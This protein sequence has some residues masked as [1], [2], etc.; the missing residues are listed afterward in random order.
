[1]PT[2]DMERLEEQA[3]AYRVNRS[4]VDTLR[5]RKKALDE[6]E[7]QL[8]ERA[9]QLQREQEAL[10]KNQQTVKQMYERQRK[11]NQLL[12][13]A[14]GK[15][16]SLTKENGSLSRAMAQQAKTIQEL[17][18]RLET[19]LQTVRG[20][21]ESLTNVVKA[22]GMLKYD[23]QDGYGVALT[24]E[25]G[26]LVDAIAKYGARWARTDGQND[27]AQ[28]METKIGISEGIQEDIQELTPKIYRGRSGRGL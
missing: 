4:E 10:R 20:A 23:K 9:E 26:R 19:A 6:R 1:M 17:E 18:K 2:E 25:Q 28:I 7:Q 3:K 13:Q 21:Y 24:E 22:V 27:L 5:K 15:I 11:V 16:S 8:D 14:E 12:E